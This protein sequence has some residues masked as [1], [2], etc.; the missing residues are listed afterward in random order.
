MKDLAVSFYSNLFAD[1]ITK[2][3]TFLMGRFPRI[4]EKQRSDLRKEYSLEEAWK[5]LMEMSPLKAPG[6]DSI[7]A[8]FFQK[9]WEVTGVALF[10][11]AMEVVE[12]AEITP[13]SNDSLP[14]LTPKEEKPYSMKGFRPISLCN[15]CIKL[16]TK[17][18]VN[19]LK[20]IWSRIIASNQA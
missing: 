4:G 5:A 2:S 1:H 14:V 9:T 12:K 11:Y 3:D 16:A 15:I 10:D 8:I 7:Q 13:G 17:M 19:K 6:P 18:L 20:E